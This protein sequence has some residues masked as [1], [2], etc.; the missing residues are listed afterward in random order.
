MR[1]IA[2]IFWIGA[3]LL[4]VV[5]GIGYSL[6]SQALSQP[7]PA[8]LPDR[9]AGL[10]LVQHTRGVQAVDEINHLHGKDF[11][12]TSAAVG[13]YGTENKATIWVS[14]APAGFIAAKILTAMRDRIA[15]GRSPFTS[16][17]ER[18]YG[19]RIIYELEGLGQKHFYFQS[20]N[21]VVWLATDDSI[22]EQALEQT[23]A[24]YP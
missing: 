12:L 10:S 15:E 16:T 9:L 1:R 18:K 7:G 24:F 4:L 13:V 2:A 21:L 6:Y 5:G 3:G 14:G 11:P 22:T 23:L 20:K 8:P 19:R 17:G